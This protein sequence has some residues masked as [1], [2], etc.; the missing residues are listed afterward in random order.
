[1]YVMISSLE[2]SKWFH[3]WFVL[4]TIYTQPKWKLYTFKMEFTIH[5]KTYLYLPMQGVKFNQL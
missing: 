1:V 5:E 3:D 4:F 2:I